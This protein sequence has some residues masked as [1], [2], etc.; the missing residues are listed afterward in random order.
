MNTALNMNAEELK[1]YNFILA[2]D[3][4]KIQT[5]QNCLHVDNNLFNYEPNKHLPFNS[6][7]NEMII[8]AEKPQIK[9]QNQTSESEFV[10]NHG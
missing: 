10:I 9:N 2:Q 8:N 6:L 4:M 7:D 1:N 3:K 5:L